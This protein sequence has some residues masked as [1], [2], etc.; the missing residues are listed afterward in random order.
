[1]KTLGS[2]LLLLVCV[3]EAQAI[4]VDSNISE[5]TLYTQGAVVT[6]SASISLAV[7]EQ[8]IELTGFPS[9]LNPQSLRLEVDNTDV[10]I[11]QV[12]VK[13]NKFLEATDPEVVS[14]KNKINLKQ[15]EIRQVTGST[16]AAELQ[17]KFLES[18]ATGYSKEAWIGSAQGSADTASWQRALALMLSGSE[19]ANK[20]IRKNILEMGKLN[21]E[22]S[23]LNRE[24]SDK[25]GL[26]ASDNSVV[27]YFSTNSAV[28]AVV[29]VHY[30]QDAA[31]WRPSYEARLNSSN[32]QLALAQKAV[33]WQSTQ[34]PWDNAKVTLSTSQPSQAMQAPELESQFFDLF[35]KQRFATAPRRKVYAS[36][37][38]DSLALEEV[39]VTAQKATERWVGSYSLNFPIAGRINV[40][41]NDDETQAYDLETFQFKAELVTQIVPLIETQ[42]FLVARFMHKGD[43][44]IYGNEMLVYVDGVLMGTAD[45]PTIL[46]GAEVSL[47]MGID[48]RIEVK[49]ND[50]GGKGGDG[51]IVKKQITEVTDLEFEITNRRAS[52]ADIEVRAVYP[53][54][55][56]KAL[57]IKRSDSATPPTSENADGKTGVALWAK[58]MRSNQ[59]WRINYAYSMTRPADRDLQQVVGK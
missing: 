14:L 3:L 10:R 41:N 31:G 53:V 49:L 21:N 25:R 38:A 50:L 15:D 27:A 5:V 16:K 18:L 58:Q 4:S 40:S 26:K 19:A 24:L 46:P 42:A 8:Q 12:N 34:E 55:K 29:K 2:V 13:E 30:Y 59:T 51:G 17:L 11:G 45:M 9:N 22:L 47:P 32:G 28:N 6:R 48:R 54:S 23:L 39:V 1:M 7:G 20:I 52:P 57:R 33:L 56:N 44:P 35:E 36:S 43:N 37:T